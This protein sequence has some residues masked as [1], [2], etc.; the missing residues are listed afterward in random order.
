MQAAR[1]IE[2]HVTGGELDLLGAEIRFDRQLAAV[3]VERI[4]QE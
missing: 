4:G 3:I 1:R 2:H